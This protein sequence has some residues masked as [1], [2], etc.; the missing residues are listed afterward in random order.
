MAQ[1]M[2]S[3][4]ASA[5]PL[6]AVLADDHR[7]FRLGLRTLLEGRGIEV[8]ADAED[9]VE[10]LRLA[11]LLRPDVVVMDLCMPRLDGVEATR[12]IVAGRSGA[13]VLVLSGSEGT[14]VL[15]ALLAG[16]RGYMLK[17]AGAERIAEAMHAAACGQMSLAPQVAGQLVER[18]RSLERACAQEKIVSPASPLTVRE[19]DVLRLLAT[20]CDNSAIGRTLFI[21]AS[22]VKHH[23]TA[24]LHKLGVEN[25]VQAAVEAVRIGAA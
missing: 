8:V 18:L 11:N 2:E 4:R 14:D 24:I 20:G 17:D 22:T 16:A 15:D 13:S 5:G 9:G 25:R 12:Q 23:V 7:L 6:R 19:C 10:A 3:W 21:S 1:G